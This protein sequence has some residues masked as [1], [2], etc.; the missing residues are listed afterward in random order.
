MLNS[1][2]FLKAI[3]E[4]A[5]DTVEAEKQVDPEEAKDQALTALTDLFNEVK[6]KNTHVIVE[7]IVADI[8]AIVKQV[9]FDGWQ[10]TTQGEREVQQALRRALLKYKLHTDQDLFDKAYGYI[11]QYY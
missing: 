10:T 3:L 1:L 9:R 7:R 8:D 2:E 11:R 6:T 5:K 4:I